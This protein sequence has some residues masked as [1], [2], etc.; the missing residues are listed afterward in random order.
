MVDKVIEVD[1]RVSLGQEWTATSD[2]VVHTLL[3]RKVFKA[4]PGTTS[5][6]PFVQRMAPIPPRLMY[7]SESMK[8]PLVWRS[9]VACYFPTVSR[10]LYQQ[11]WMEQVTI[12]L[13]ISSSCMAPLS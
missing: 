4:S 8:P 6:I 3:Q 2:A 11:H 1:L 7:C 12:F 10:L 5:T 9:N 13:A